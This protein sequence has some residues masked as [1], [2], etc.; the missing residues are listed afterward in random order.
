MNDNVRQAK[1]RIREID[2][3]LADRERLLEERQVLQSVVDFYEDT[4][5]ERLFK[6]LTLHVVP[7]PNRLSGVDK[8]F[9]PRP[10]SQTSKIL[11]ETAKLLEAAPDHILPFPM[12]TESLP[13]ELRPGG[14]T[15]KEG[16]RTAIK[17][18]GG[19]FG[20]VYETGGVVRLTTR[21]PQA[22]EA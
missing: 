21:S 16:I 5:Q 9:Y 8:R 12:V 4:V 22:V 7:T 6:P 3:Q 20:I 18:A 19:R 10:D 15:W 17:R 2:A 1:A 11:M 13:V 14:H